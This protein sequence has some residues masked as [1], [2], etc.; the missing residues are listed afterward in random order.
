LLPLAAPLLHRH[1]HTAGQGTLDAGFQSGFGGLRGHRISSFSEPFEQS[2]GRWK[3]LL[4]LCWANGTLAARI[5]RNLTLGFSAVTGDSQRNLSSANE[6]S[7]FVAV[8]F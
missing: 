6:A 7:A 1:R 4:D 8:K 3:S 2:F 5:N